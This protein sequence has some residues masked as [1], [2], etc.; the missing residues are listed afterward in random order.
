MFAGIY[1]GGMYGGSTT[2]ILLNTPGRVGVGGHRDRGL[3]D[4]QARAAAG[5]ASRP[6]RSA[7]SSPGR[8]GPSLLTFLAQ[9]V[10]RPRGHVPAGRLLRADGAGL[11]GGHG[12]GRRAR[13]CAG[14]SPVLRPVHRPDRDRPATGQARLTFGVDQLLDGVDI[15][16]VAVGLFAVGEALYVASR[17]RRAPRRSRPGRGRRWL[18]RDDCA[19]LVAAV[20]ARHRAGLPVRRAAVR[21]RGD[22]DVPLLRAR[23]AARAQ[24]RT[25]EFGK[26]AIEGVAGPEAA[27]NAAFAGVLVPLLTLGH[28]DLGDRRDPH[29]RVPDLRPPAR[30][31]SCSRTTRTWCG[32]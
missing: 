27:N 26:G 17:L 7:P 28:P 11:R 5:P 18:S 6:P 8:S 12:A 23:E 19:A 22:P 32:R 15:V 29:R 21:R 24:A 13:W 16:V 1:Y 25:E 20:A 30:A 9:P 10:A 31:R 14:C 2:S 3:P 4:G